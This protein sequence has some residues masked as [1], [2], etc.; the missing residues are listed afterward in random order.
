MVK[1]L[2]S[3]IVGLSLV[4]CGSTTHVTP[5]PDPTDCGSVAS[6]GFRQKTRVKN[7]TCTAVDHA[8]LD[9]KSK[10]IWAKKSI[11]WPAKS[12]IKVA[13]LNGSQSQIDKT[14]ARFEVVDSICNLKFERAIL[15]DRSDVRVY[16]NP[17][18]GHWSYMGIYC[19][20]IPQTQKTMNIGLTSSDSEE[21]FDRVVVHEV[22]HAVGFWHEH[23]H[24]F[25]AIPWNVPKV[26]EYYR[27]TQGWSD[28]QIYAQ[29]LNRQTK[30]DFIGSSFDKDSIMEYPVPAELTTNGF[31]VGWNYKL[32]PCDIAEIQKI[33]PNQ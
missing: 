31:S 11:L 32:S 14:W 33:Y 28:Q 25:S 12:T 21:E 30:E 15:G 17:N 13:F 5:L 18:D 8:T 10:K 22:L 24:P 20:Q 1:F 2:L 26:L 7:E 3:V 29:V 6:V 9:P 27:R 19:K 16:F 4:A 23:Q